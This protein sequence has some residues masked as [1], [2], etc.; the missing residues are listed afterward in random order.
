MV[1][2]AAAGSVD[3]RVLE[4]GVTATTVHCT[5]PADLATDLSAP[6][7]MWDMVMLGDG[8]FAEAH[9]AGIMLTLDDRTVATTAVVDRRA[10]GFSIG[11][12]ALHQLGFDYDPAQDALVTRMPRMG[13][14][15]TMSLEEEPWT[16]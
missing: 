2:V 15:A 6:V 4:A 10:E 1:R 13:W 11:R 14:R 7:R 12:I 9:I 3:S 8:T 5:L 16:T